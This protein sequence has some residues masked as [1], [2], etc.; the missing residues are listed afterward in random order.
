MINEVVGINSLPVMSGERA[1][2][3]NIKPQVGVVCRGERAP[4]LNVVVEMN[5]IRDRQ[6]SEDDVQIC[7]NKQ[8]LC[9]E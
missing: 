5:I 2:K 1:R 6:R 7:W 3:I 8:S 4:S 9:K